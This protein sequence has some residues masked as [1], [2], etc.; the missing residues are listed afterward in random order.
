MALMTYDSRTIDSSGAFLV[1]ELERLDQ[2]LHMPLVS[3][4]WN[5]DI[6]LR[7]DVTIGDEAS[8]YTTTSLAASGG[9]RPAGK[10]WIGP[11]SKAV[12]GISVDISKKS[13]PLHL[14][15]MELGWSIPELVAA[16]QVGRP[17]DSQKYEGLKLKHNMDVDEMV[18]VGDAEV[19]V[20][21]LINNAD[22]TP[23]SIGGGWATATALEILED[24][25][26]LIAATWQ[27]SG[28]ALCPTHLL[29]PPAKFS[30]LTKPVTEAGSQSLLEYIAKSCL[31]ASQ[32]G[33]PLQIN[34][35]K[36]CVGRG[37]AAADRMVAYTKD[38]ICVRYPLVPLQRTPMENR[39]VFQL[40]TYFGK[41]GQ[42][43]FVYPETVGYA[44]GL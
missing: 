44:D 20:S 32:N 3:V 29:L 18:Y 16:Q 11:V 12:P 19:G 6:D 31:S 41:L 23:A 33:R 35:V 40:T 15:G 38:P 36:W 27:Q 14:W 34:P 26:A 43:E 8:S 30:L 25:N 4:T 39:G 5:R 2:T 24:I 42:V 21:G 7:E 13:K 1:G 22:I 9:A 17:V 37:V 28:Y 10:N